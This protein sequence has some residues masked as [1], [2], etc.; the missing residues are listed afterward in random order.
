MAE[1][2][3]YL[4]EGIIGD[5]YIDGDPDRIEKEE[6]QPLGEIHQNKQ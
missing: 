6:G 1:L 4:I 5:A 2:L 3:V